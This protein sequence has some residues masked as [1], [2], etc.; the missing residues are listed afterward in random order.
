MPNVTIKNTVTEQAPA[1]L[2]PFQARP[3]PELTVITNTVNMTMSIEASFENQGSGLFRFNLYSGEIGVFSTSCV[4]ASNND[5]TPCSD[6]PY[7]AVPYLDNSE[8][9]T[10]DNKYLE[11][12]GSTGQEISGYEYA[13]MQFC[14][15]VANVTNALFPLCM[16]PGSNVTAIEYLDWSYIQG[17]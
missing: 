5:A 14:F 10:G 15:P 17:Q 2:G 16:L 1:A 7:N 9:I 8:F 4:Q 13:Q 11:R 6:S 3:Y 12:S